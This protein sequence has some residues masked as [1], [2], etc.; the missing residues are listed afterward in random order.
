MRIMLC[1]AYCLLSFFVLTCS[2]SNAWG[3]YPGTTVTKPKEGAYSAT[4]TPLIVQSPNLT[5]TNVLTSTSV[6]TWPRTSTVFSTGQPPSVQTTQRNRERRLENSDQPMNPIVFIILSLAALIIIVI[7]GV[8]L[9]KKCLKKR[10]TERA[11]AKN[12][13]QHQVDYNSLV[14]S[15]S[16]VEIESQRDYTYNNEIAPSSVPDPETIISPVYATVEFLPRCSIAEDYANTLR[17]PGFL[18]G[19]PIVYAE[20]E[21]QKGD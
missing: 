6:S 13:H 3:T 20:I 5:S 16:S 2:P 4:L 12:D 10:K 7:L 11:P 14:Q 21:T 18:E 9:K 17:T 8:F 15:S 19:E 1:V